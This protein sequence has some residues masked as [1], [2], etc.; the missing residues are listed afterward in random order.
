MASGQESKVRFVCVG[1]TDVGRVR[2]HNEDNFLVANLAGDKRGTSGEVLEGPVQQRGLALVVADGMGGAAAGEVASQMAV[3]MLHGE[4]KDADLGGTVRSE[5]NVI[6]LLEGAIN[7][8]NESIFK[9]GQESKEHQGMG[10]TLTAAVVLGDSLYL[11]QVG[12]SRGYVLR[13]GKLVQMTRD[14]SLI[15]QL[16]EEGTLTE[17]QAEKLGGKNIILQALGVEESLKVDSKRYDI[18]RGD[19]LLLNSDGLS[20]MVPDAKMEEIL[21]AEPD[22]SKAAKKLI[23]AANAGGGKDNITCILARFDGEGLREP[24]SPLTD[25]ERAGGSFRA[26]PPP[27]SKAGRNAV[28]ATAA[29]LAVIGVVLFR[30]QPKKLYVNTVPVGG[31]V[32]VEGA[33]EGGPEGFEAQPQEFQAGQDVLFSLPKDKEFEVTVSAPGYVPGKRHVST[34]VDTLEI[35]TTFEL[36][37]IPGKSLDL[38]PPPYKGKPL[39]RVKVK[40][41]GREKQMPPDKFLEAEVKDDPASPEFPS[42]FPAGGWKYRAERNGF[43]PLEKDFEVKSEEAAVLAVDPMTEALGTLNATSLPPGAT[44]T[45]FDEG[46][47]LLEKPAAVLA[48]RSTGPQSV[49]A[50]E[51]VVKATCEGYLFQDQRVQVEAKKEK[52]ANFKANPGSL[53]FKGTPNGYVVLTPVDMPGEKKD[54]YR[55]MTNGQSKKG[56]PAPGTYKAAYTDP[57][58]G[59]SVP[60]ELKIQPGQLLQDLDAATGRP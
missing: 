13:K 22:M 17:E 53:S 32:K 29:V 42:T 45:I 50:T 15:G 39:S 59:D 1:L 2:E 8:A 5:Q 28:I 7:K 36:V 4:F 51:V 44:V 3:D 48:T 60:Y 19:I 18:L 43:E 20:G 12:D 16:I 34:K 26:P 11:S 52:E 10:T 40:L 41:F 33:A 35:R 57:A 55:I 6:A 58:K 56:T 21:A 24:L 49:R 38:G 14:Q 47:S 31:T 46:E 54:T 9:K 37:R 25:E 23:E 30:P 27:K